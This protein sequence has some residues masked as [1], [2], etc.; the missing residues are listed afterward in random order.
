MNNQIF[1]DGINSQGKRIVITGTPISI[2]IARGK[3]VVLTNIESV[4]DNR[5]DDVLAN[6]MEEQGRL[7]QALQL[8]MV[9]VAC[10][11]NRFQSCPNG[12]ESIFLMEKAMLEDP[13]IHHHLFSTL[14]REKCK[15]ESAVRS[16][17]N[18]Y[19]NQ[20]INSPNRYLHERSL[21]VFDLKI[22]LLEALKNPKG[23]MRNLKP[24][25]SRRGSQIG[26]IAV[27]KELTPRF[28]LERSVEGFK[29]I[30][31][32]QGGASSHAAILCRALKIPAVSG[33]RDACALMEQ[34][35]GVLINGETGTVIL[36][37]NRKD[38]KSPFRRL[39]GGPGR[40]PSSRPRVA[41]RKLILMENV[42]FS[43]HATGAPETE[44]VGLYRTEFEF[45]K[46]HRMLDEDEQAA[47]YG[48]VVRR[49]KNRPVNI[50]MLDVAEDKNLALF[51]KSLSWKPDSRSVGV[52]FLL[53]HPDLFRSQARAIA[54]ASVQGN[55]GVIYPMIADLSQFL[56]LKVLFLQ[57]T[58]D[59]KIPRIRHGVMLE[60]PSACLR[61]SA[62]LGYADFADI[63][64]NDLIK[65]LFGLDRNSVSE[66][67]R[68]ASQHPVLWELLELVARA[69]REK[70]KPLIVCG[71]MA[72]DP[73]CVRRFL[74]LG[75][76][77]ISLAPEAIPPLLQK[78]SEQKTDP[79]GPPIPEGPFLT[80]SLIQPEEVS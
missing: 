10:S 60:V 62:L 44:G 80:D 33:I 12:T 54:R 16:I 49:M 77:Q 27:A 73:E 35:V 34:G 63:G 8:M 26:R 69:G 57:A 67:G 11:E 41:G 24:R 38:G 42:I 4:Q 52:Q 15:A 66:F 14:A 39:T 45:L 64:T 56:R 20:L 13:Q 55:V 47:L 72:H 29:G 61:A 59:L 50:R 53:D 6:V 74:R 18:G 46:T 7:R 37:P 23:L 9:V 58:A 70:R 28:V 19:Q 78:L 43:E 22:G 51:Q 5:D 3:A 31:T 25:A 65:H 75:L 30:V 32:E 76:N 48:A 71:E 36:E 17:L 79:A 2:G 40:S 1:S 21:D 68:R